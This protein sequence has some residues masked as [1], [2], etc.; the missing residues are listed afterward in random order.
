MFG[1]Y[2]E[3]TASNLGDVPAD[4]IRKQTLVNAERFVTPELKSTR[5]ILDAQERSLELEIELFVESGA[6]RSKTPREFSK[7]LTRSRGSMRLPRSLSVALALVTCD[8][9]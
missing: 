5:R 3:I 8:R 6:R 2:I 1:Y 9:P 7:S 4:Y